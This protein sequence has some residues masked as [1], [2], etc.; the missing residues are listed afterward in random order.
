MFDMLAKLQDVIVHSVTLHLE[1]P[2]D[3]ATRTDVYTK[4][5]SHQGFEHDEGSWRRISQSSAFPPLKEISAKQ[6][7][8]NNGNSPPN[9][10]NQDE[11]TLTIQYEDTEGDDASSGVTVPRGTTQGWFF[12]AIDRPAVLSN[13]VPDLVKNG[14]LN[15]GFLKAMDSYSLLQNRVL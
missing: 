11:Y 7:S 8:S 10:S 9:A 6:G 15:L 1:F 13:N 3:I 14:V 4:P 12:S 5:G 2:P